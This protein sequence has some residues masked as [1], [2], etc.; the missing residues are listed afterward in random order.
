MELI[1]T[2]PNG[3]VVLARKLNYV[4]LVFLKNCKSC[5]QNE[6]ILQVIFSKRC[7][8][9]LKNKIVHNFHITY[10]MKWIK[11]FY[12]DKN[13]I[14]EKKIFEKKILK[15]WKFFLLPSLPCFELIWA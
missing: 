5:I 1:Y 3:E 14:Y 6:W 7:L 12:V 11:S 2:N 9:Y 4:E 8:D 10:S 15:I 13:I